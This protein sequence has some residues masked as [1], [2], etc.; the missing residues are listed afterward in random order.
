[1]GRKKL[2][3]NAREVLRPD[4]QLA[5]WARRRKLSEHLKLEKSDLL[6]DELY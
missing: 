4:N 5:L 1:M 6:I 2:V 3:T